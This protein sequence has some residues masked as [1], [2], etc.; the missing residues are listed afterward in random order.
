M[1]ELPCCGE[2]EEACLELTFSSNTMI[3]WPSCGML[4]APWWWSSPC[5]MQEAFTQCNNA[6]SSMQ[7]CFSVSICHQACGAT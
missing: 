7:A 1:A 4:R 3:F 6:L 5:G 2:G